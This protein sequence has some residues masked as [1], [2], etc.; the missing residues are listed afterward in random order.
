M[1]STDYIPVDPDFYDIIED[2]QKLDG[3]SLVHYFGKGIDIEDARG[4]ISGI[5]TNEKHE[6]FLFIDQ[7]K[8]IRLDRIITING[9]PG[10]AFDEYDSYARACMD[11]RAGLD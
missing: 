6:E 8:K 2:Q 11:C 7:D 5:I 10:P 3:L 9:K 4:R 1:N